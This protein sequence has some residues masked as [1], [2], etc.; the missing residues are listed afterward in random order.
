MEGERWRERGGGREVEVSNDDYSLLDRNTKR[1]TKSS[2]KDDVSRS[3]LS[4][5]GLFFRALLAPSP[6]YKKTHEVI[7]HITCLI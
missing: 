1:P 3:L 5:M 4:V 7:I 6:D 2:S